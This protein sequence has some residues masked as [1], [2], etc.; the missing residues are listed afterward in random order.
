MTLNELLGRLQG[1]KKSG[2]NYAARCPAHHDRNASLSLKADSDRILVNCHTG[3][4][5]ENVVQALGLTMA[6][7]FLKDEPRTFRNSGSFESRIAETYDYTDERGDVLFQAVRLRDPKDFRQRR[8]TA[9]GWEW[10]LGDVR[11]V[12][13]RLP[14]LSE[15]AFDGR[16]VWHCEGEKDAD[17]LAALG[18]TATC[19]PMGASKGEDPG[20]RWPDEFVV[21]FAGCYG[22]FLVMD[23]DEPGREFARA[24][25]GKLH[26]A[27]VRCKV[28]DLA[29][30]RSDGYDVSDFLLEHGDDA[31]PMLERLARETPVW[32]RNRPLRAPV[33]AAATFRERVGDYD[34][35]REYLGPFLY[36][37]E[38]VHVIGPVNQ[39]KSTFVQ[40]A[41]SAAL[42]GREFLGWRGSGGSLRG[43]YV[44]LEQ[45]EHAL[46]RGLT[47]ARL[48]APQLDGRFDVWHEPDGLEVDRNEQHRLML[49]DLCDRYQVVVVDPWYKLIGDELADGMRNVRPVISF[50]DGLR[51]QHPRTVVVCCRHSNE[52]EGRLTLGDVSGYKAYERAA[53][54]TVGFQRVKGDLSRLVWLKSRSHLLP[55]I[56]ESWL[57]EW[58]RGQGFRRVGEDANQERIDVA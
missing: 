57:V 51:K 14:G 31:K 41:L 56:G 38:R 39:G 46:H 25:A 15:A 6:D 16:A 36:G 12:L 13:Y 11:R 2:G 34:P 35:S 19:N 49:A 7:L 21:H 1:V 33:V 29:P 9:N 27:G 5:T 42:H 20:V 43:V 32:P 24:V 52:K 47:D 8:K 30:R 53:D 48:Y 55:K 22:V 17:A 4:S 10:G 23:C 54:V 28:L 45:P 50:L 40:E 26:K 44:D 58:T 37:G 3:C 18:Y